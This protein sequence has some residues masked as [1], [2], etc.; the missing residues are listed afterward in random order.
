MYILNTSLNIYYHTKKKSIVLLIKNKTTCLLVFFKLST[1]LDVLIEKMQHFP[2]IQ[3]NI[4]QYATKLLLQQ[5]FTC[6]QF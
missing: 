3:D 4:K 6:V 2:Y 1:S 5:L